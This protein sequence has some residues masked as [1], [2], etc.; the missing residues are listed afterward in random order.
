[1]KISI[2]T[3]LAVHVGILS[4]QALKPGNEV[5]TQA[6][7]EAR[8][9]QGEAPESWKPGNVYILECWATWCGPCI[10]AIPHVDALYDKYHT[11]GLNIIG[12]NVFEDGEAKVRKFVLKK[13]DGMSYPVAYVG[14]GGAFETS[15]LV[16]AGVMGIPH[17]FIVKDGKLLFGIHPA[18]I[19]EDMVESLLAGGEREKQVVAEIML[20]QK[21]GDEIAALEEKFHTAMAQSDYPNAE[22]TISKIEA[23]DKNYH[24]LGMYKCMLSMEKNEWDAAIGH[25]DSIQNAS[26]RKGVASMLFMNSEM[27][28]KK[29][30]ASFLAGLVGILSKETDV[31]APGS[32]LEPAALAIILYK[33][34]KKPEA[35]KAAELAVSNAEAMANQGGGFDFPV[36]P[37]RDFLT[38]LNED[39]PMSFM[40]LMQAI[41]AAFS[42]GAPA[43]T[44][45]Q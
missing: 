22:S 19:S 24:A 1:M 26:A 28:N 4:A 13:K 32:P 31:E 3:A 6:I 43:E 42:E 21:S 27:T 7:R 41:N 45:Q 11:R 29:L 14:N 16:P 35:I 23:L 2:L 39:K 40:E 10:D 33:L 9:I 34:E 37:F 44:Q 18:S 8:F 12:M 25:I 15:W 38:S 30:P 5:T 20:A 36:K 17:A